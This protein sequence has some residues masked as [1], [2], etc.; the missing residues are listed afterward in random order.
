MKIISPGGS[1]SG[2]D[3]RG[4]CRS[5]G[6]KEGPC[7]ILHLNN[8]TGGRRKVA[9]RIMS[10]PSLCGRRQFEGGRG[11]RKIWWGR[12]RRIAKWWLSICLTCIAGPIKTSTMNLQLLYPVLLNAKFFKLTSSK[13]GSCEHG[14]DRYAAFSTSRTKGLLRADC[15]WCRGDETA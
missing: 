15:C 11:Q 13:G 10:T 4:R 6:I 8:G 14:R 9:L 1:L 12:R 7:F 5:R 3:S 2:R